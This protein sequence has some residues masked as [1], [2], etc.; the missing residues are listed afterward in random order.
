MKLNSITFMQT[1]RIPGLRP[2]ELNE[3][4]LENPP[5]ALRGWRLEIRGASVFLIS[6]PGWTRNTPCKASDMADYDARY[7][8]STA[9]STIH[10]VP[11]MN[12]FLHWAGNAGEVEKIGKTFLTQPLGVPEF[13]PAPPEQA[14][15]N[16]LSAL[17]NKDLGDA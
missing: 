12:C 5:E 14:K 10:E 13:A 17:G 2:G 9:P 3:M 1:P 4:T 11:R 8:K 16:L 15:P 7:G 6:P